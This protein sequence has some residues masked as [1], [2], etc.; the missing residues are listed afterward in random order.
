MYIPGMAR[1]RMDGGTR[2][3]FVEPA[4]PGPV[5]DPPPRAP[6]QLRAPC[7]ELCAATSF[8]F[9][10][11]ASQPEEMVATAVAGGADAL[12]VAD[13]HGLYGVVRAFAEARRLNA[14]AVVGAA[15]VTRAPDGTAGPSVLL[16]PVSRSGYARLC[17]LLTRGHADRPKGSC[18]VALADVCAS[19]PGL[20]AVVLPPGLD[21]MAESQPDLP[22]RDLA[23]AWDAARDGCLRALKES[24]GERLSVALVRRLSDQDARHD[25]WARDAHQQ[26]GIARLATSR[27]LMH[28]GWR[29]PLQDVLTCIRLGVRLFDA[30]TVLLPNAEARLLTPLELAGRFSDAPDALR[31]TREVADACRGF[32]LG[33][34]RYRFPADRLMPGE[35]AQGRLRALTFEG[36]RRRYGGNVPDAVSRQL[37]HELDLIEKIDVAPYFLTVHDIVE[38]ARARHILCQGRGSAA[39]S[40]VCYVLGVTSV[41]PVRMQ[42]LFERFLSVERGEP[43]DIDVDFEHERREEVIQDIYN[44]WGREHAGM[45]AEVICYRGRSAIREAGKVVGLDDDTLDRMSGLMIHS[46]LRDV[47][48]ARLADVGIQSASREVALTL[49]LSRLL[50]G[51]PRHLSI[52]VGGFILTHDALLDTVPIEP[53]AMEARTVIQWDKDDVDTLGIFKMDVLGLGMLTALRKCMDLVRH[54]GG[55]AMELWSIPPEDPAVYAAIQKA[56]TVGVFQIE[57][58]AQM[59]MLPRL[60]PASFYDLVI[61]VA[62]VRPGPIQGDM[63]HP[64]L[65]RR[66]GEEP[67][68]Y[69]HPALA[70]I[71]ERTL[72]VPLFQE[73]V[74]KLAVVGAGYTPGEAD[75]LRRDMAAWRK[76][77]RLARHRDKLLRGFEKNGV[78]AE[79]AE[80]LYAQVQGFGEYGFPESHAASFA[81]LTY[82]SSYLKVHH[83]AAFCA[84]IIN[85]LPM[86]FYTPSSLVQDAQRH[87][88]PVLPVDARHSVWDC[89]LER[90]PDGQLA[91]RLGFRLVKGL[92]REKVE[93]LVQR[94]DRGE[95]LVDMAA[96]MGAAQWR[97]Q[98]LFALSGSGAMDG[99][100]GGRREALW[101]GLGVDG[102]VRPDNPAPRLTTG[103]R[104]EEA[105][106]R[107]PRVGKMEQLM[108]D[109]RHTGLS[110]A[111]HPLKHLRE[112]LARQ[113]VVRCADLGTLTHGTPVRVAGLAITRQQPGTASGVVFLTLEDET[114]TA[115]IVLWNRV[116]Q[117]FHAL[118]RSAPLVIV[119]GR[120]ER[121]GEVIHVIAEHLKE[122][123]LPAGDLAA[124]SR[125]FH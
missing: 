94:R 22:A 67:V 41:D 29:K 95:G 21:L 17:R 53:G 44:R 71:L 10:H 31:R 6:D 62:I 16:Y 113:R 25:R 109:Y 116:F 120:V 20:H 8:S 13:W 64:Y 82:A 107:L 30:G 2:M 48:A 38:T 74:M 28:A 73:Q 98:E 85:S 58:R 7:V 77:G 24:F 101:E 4:A 52:H 40:A 69:P 19:A 96:A 108:L 32:S 124:R 35:T 42:L 122:L 114:G 125:D 50:Q 117:K 34:L 60:K 18:V 45:V 105:A 89:T 103:L 36:A 81:L 27:P 37:L 23:V 118:A 111:D 76:N 86:G 106:P 65:R 3:P 115:N 97:P 33:E 121:D 123:K 92:T 61:E 87:G 80:R 90:Q 63:V 46:S 39:N 110:V 56:D 51:I 88:V 49:R 5:P 112:D 68:E 12:G 119:S 11:G 83:P 91:L 70:P 9:L 104:T 54:T 55:P 78:P 72:G 14:R 43:P 26:L 100:A 57:S 93:A 47:Q 59:A 79:F 66:R 99:L 1:M 75:Q 15:L 84:A 102:A